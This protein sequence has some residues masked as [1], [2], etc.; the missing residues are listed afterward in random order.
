[1]ELTIDGKKILGLLDTGADRSIIA[2]RDWIPGW[3]V[4]ASSQT[5]QGLDYA[6]APDVS[7]RQLK[8]QDREGHSGVMQP[9]VLELPVS[10]WGRDLLKNMGFKLSN[11][12]SDF[13]QR[14]M[15]DMGY[16]PGFGIGKYLQGHRSPMPFQQRQKK[17][18]LSFS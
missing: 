12:Y 1:M 8:W 3:P 2:K 17:Q 16:A 18:G 7:A 13:T 10:L 11:E 6:K 15:Q 14:M 5:S 9:Y 4:Q